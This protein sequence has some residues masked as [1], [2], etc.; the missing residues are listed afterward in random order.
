MTLEIL[1]P[2]KKSTRAEVEK[3]YS[4]GNIPTAHR[5][6]YGKNN[7]QKCP[8]N[9]ANKNNDTRSQENLKSFN[10]GLNQLKEKEG[11]PRVGAFTPKHTLHNSDLKK[12]TMKP[13]T[14]PIIMLTTWQLMPPS[15]QSCTAKK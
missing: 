6:S 14:M 13:M 9:W 15:I 12:L 1:T 4:D 2:N 10:Q 8:H 5:K 3:Q 7:G 11:L